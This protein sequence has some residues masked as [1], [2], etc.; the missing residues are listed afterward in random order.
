MFC[1]STWLFSRTIPCLTLIALLSIL[2]SRDTPTSLRFFG[3]NSRFCL[4]GQVFAWPL[5]YLK[6]SRVAYR[7]RLPMVALLLFHI[8]CCASV[9]DTVPEDPVFAVKTGLVYSRR[10]IEKAIAA[11]GKCPVSDTDLSTDDLVPVTCKLQFAM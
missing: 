10:L 8:V 4:G 11:D 1:A 7:L 3:G 6:I 2:V 9:S 5:L